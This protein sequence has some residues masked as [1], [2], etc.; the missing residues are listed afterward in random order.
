[1]L[2]QT[3]ADAVAQM[4]RFFGDFILYDPSM[5]TDIRAYFGSA[6]HPDPHLNAVV[7]ET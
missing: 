4:D 5:A 2:P 7:R 6:E 1:M 3:P